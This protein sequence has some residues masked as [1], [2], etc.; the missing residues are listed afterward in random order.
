MN[1]FLK[2][3]FQNSASWRKVSLKLFFWLWVYVGLCV[4]Q[5]ITPHNTYFCCL[6]VETCPARVYWTLGGVMQ[7]YNEEVLHWNIR[8]VSSLSKGESFLTTVWVN[9]W[10]HLRSWITRRTLFYYSQLRRRFFKKNLAY[11]TSD[12]KQWIWWS[13]KEHWTYQWGIDMDFDVCA[14][15][16]RNRHDWCK[17]NK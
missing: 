1:I 17:G 10:L 3:I 13:N 2:R 7:G 12:W 14:W 16:G 4:H 8:R 9:G 11:Q 15:P 6:T 5:E